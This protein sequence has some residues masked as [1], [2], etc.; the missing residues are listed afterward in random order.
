MDTCV[1]FWPL[2]VG[3]YK[4][5]VREKIKCYRLL[6]YM[7]NHPNS[8]GVTFLRGEIFFTMDKFFFSNSIGGMLRGEKF[9]TP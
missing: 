8:M 5:H 3:S 9:F 4:V 1:Y 6:A 2:F 7:G